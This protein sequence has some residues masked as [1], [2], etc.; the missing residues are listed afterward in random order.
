MKKYLIMI[1]AAVMILM[2]AACGGT[3]DKPAGETPEGKG[4][5]QEEAAEESVHPYAWLGLEDMPE[6]D[7]L[8]A[9]ASNKYYKESDNYIKD[10]SYVSKEINARDGINSYK[11]NE[12]SLV[13]SVDGK[14]YSINENSKSYMEKD[15]SD[16]AEDLQEQYDSAM[17]NGTNI[18]GRKAYGTGSE[19]VPIYSKEKGDDDLP[20]PISSW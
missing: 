14:T 5:E 10:M 2:L 9:L 6:C 16:M 1:T 12:N 20:G 17:E 15:M 13:Y 4:T 19:A 7:Y 3:S 18:Y 8:D 11:K